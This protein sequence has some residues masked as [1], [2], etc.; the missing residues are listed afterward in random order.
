MRIYVASSVF[1]QFE[2]RWN[3]EIAQGIKRNLPGA[4][5]VLPQDFKMSRKFNDKQHFGALFK[6]CIEE[7]D[8]CDALVAVLDGADCDSGT[9]FEVGYAYA[10]RKPIIGLRTDF[11]KSQEKGVNIMLSRAC[12][13]FIPD[14]SFR[15]DSGLIVQD[16]VR[17]LKQIGGRSQTSPGPKTSAR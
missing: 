6:M 4:V 13:H 7:I 1:T 9:S 11:R 2:R 15:E 3:R 10:L 14:L 16:I 5:V 12:T 8:K 17:R